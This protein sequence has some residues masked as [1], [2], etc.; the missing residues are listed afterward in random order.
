MAFRTIP[1][2]LFAFSAACATPFI[3]TY[4]F[5]CIASIHK[6]V[7]STIQVIGLARYK[8]EASAS[9]AEPNCSGIGH[10]I[11]EGLFGFF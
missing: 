9:T 11:G 1:L 10:T 5:L 6:V 7:K 8:V 3:W 4:L 2:P